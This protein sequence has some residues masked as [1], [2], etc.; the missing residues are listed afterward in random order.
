M[1]MMLTRN[2]KAAEIIDKL[3]RQREKVENDT[4]VKIVFLRHK[5]KDRKK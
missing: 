3:G 5:T 1:V 2:I 4:I